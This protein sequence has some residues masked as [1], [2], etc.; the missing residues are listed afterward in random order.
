[1]SAQQSEPDRF[2]SKVDRGSSDECW[3][4][5]GATNSEDRARFFYD[6]ENRAAAR[7]LMKWRNNVG[8]QFVL[9]T[10][11]NPRCVNP[12][13]LYLGDH[14]DNIQDAYENGG[15]DMSGDN[16]SNATLSDSDVR[17]IWEKYHNNPEVTQ[18]DLAD[19]YPVIRSRIA[20]I[21]RMDETEV[22]SL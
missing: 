6:G 5:Q 2:W 12:D 22:K 18:Y 16:N 19:E 14:S 4:W 9:H 3:E 15:L 7:V 11:D 13:H 10:C 20:Q 8:E 21:T 1:M 17:D